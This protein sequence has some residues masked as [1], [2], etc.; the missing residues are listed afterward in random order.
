MK[1]S[2]VF[3]K[4]ISSILLVTVFTVSNFSLYTKKVNAQ[5]IG[6]SASGSANGGFNAQGIGA[7]ALGC[8]T[9]FFIQRKAAK[10]AATLAGRAEGAVVG[11][12]GSAVQSVTGINP[13]SGVVSPQ[14][15]VVD[16]AVPVSIKAEVG[17][18]D[19]ETTLQSFKEECLDLIAR[20]VVLKIMDKITF[21]TVEWINSGF[22]GNPFYPED[23]A[24]FFEQIAKDEVTS[25]TAWFS[26]NPEDY[27]F[28][29][30]IS[31]TILLTVRNRLQDN[32]RFS[33]NQ[34][35]QSNNQYASY[36]NFQ[37]RFSVGGWAGYTAFAQPNN[38]IFGNYLM[39]QNHLARRTAGTNITVAA[40]FQKELAEAGGLLN[41]R[42]CRETALG[43]GEEDYIAADEPLHL[44]NSPLIPPGLELPDAVYEGLPLAVQEHLG[45]YESGGIAIAMAQEYN[46]LVNQSKCVRWETVTPG[47]F[48]AEQT[49]QV[50]GSPFRNL[51]L[52]DEFNE[53][54]G[55][56][57]D[58]LAAQ[59]FEQGLRA[60]QRTDG[61]YSSDINDP[62]YNA[63]WAQSNN[64]DFGSSSNQS[65]A[66]EF[67]QGGGASGG[68]AGDENLSLLEVQQN[69]VL[70]G[71]LAVQGLTTLIRDI[72][73][74]DYCVPG[75]NP[76]WY[77]MGAINLQN[78][79]SSTVSESGD[80]TY[81]A[82]MVNQMTGINIP[83]SAVPNFTQFNAFMN[84]TLGLYRDEVFANYS[85]LAPPPAVRGTA[86]NMFSQ[87]EGYQTQIQ[88]IQSRINNLIPIIPQIQAVVNQFNAL[89]PAQQADPNSP[90][91]QTITSLLTQLSNQG[92]LVTQ[93]QLQG[94]NG[95]VNLY[96]SQIAAVNQY[97]SQCISEVS[98]NGYQGLEERVQYPFPSIFE[99]TL[100]NQP[101]L[102]PNVNRYLSNINFGDSN[103][104]INL[105]GFN[106]LG[107]T[108]P[109]TSTETFSNY[110]QSLY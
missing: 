3:K 48:I 85:P 69:Y 98:G 56:I 21:M 38:N 42:I 66:G 8:G 65:S 43:T 78:T 76:R 95:D 88:I 92:S 1:I 26:M 90:E 13:T 80:G 94:L 50:L 74:L 87:I 33:L 2:E 22:E 100:I 27:P 82:Q 71:S 77:E 53:N 109:T 107:L 52:A 96:E 30:I 14:V 34:V 19:T 108:I 9:A 18:V 61:D 110:L 44:A 105:S 10:A 4:I 83:A 64:P 31:E 68:N 17:K 15:P 24:N 67:I 75:P 99:N 73:A 45:D 11:E 55:L 39:A 47:R 72:R 37:A 29:R 7:V 102:S 20:Y 104:E 97:I 12:A 89:T 49:S 93:E 41:Q 79:I 70:Q 59:L 91:M 103:N 46:T 28:G 23:R 5:A 51:E 54:L 58:T 101:A 62:N 35:L 40:N 6:A 86:T 57:L 25:F 81:Y 36:E 106:N 84:F 32:M 60:F 16:K 63:I